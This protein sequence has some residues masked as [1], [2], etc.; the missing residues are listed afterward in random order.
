MAYPRILPATLMA[1][2]ALT[3]LSGCNIARYWWQYYDE[4]VDTTLREPTGYYEHASTIEVQDVLVVPEDLERPLNDTSLAV[5]P[6]PAVTGAMIGSAADIRPPIVPLRLDIGISG[7]YSEN[8]AIIWFDSRGS[9]GIHTEDDALHLMERMLSNIGVEIGH[10]SDESY[11]LTTQVADYDEF[12]NR[13]TGG[14]SGLRYVQI[15]RLRVG[16]SQRGGLGIATALMASKTLLPGQFFAG[17]KTLT[18][19]L[20]DV[21][22]QRFAMGFS[23]QIINE[24]EA[25][26]SAH[27]ALPA[28]VTITLEPDNNG[29]QTFVVNAPYD[30]TVSVLRNMLPKF[31]I[32][33]KEYSI[34]HS[35][36]SIE[37]DDDDPAIFSRA[38][39]DAFGLPER[40]FIVRVGIVG[41]RTSVTFYDSDDKPLPD[42]QVNRLYSGFSQAMARE[43]LLFSEQG[44]KYGGEQA[45]VPAG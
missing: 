10:L 39:V 17:T 5:P 26:T 41:G 23:N 15:Y 43:F 4:S 29:R 44:L 13:Y 8:E 28:E 40:D 35:R 2:L 18:D 25:Q 30:A 16:R 20:S 14:S 38:G 37:V 9:H 6:L 1:T 34:S 45:A 32:I 22:L 42:A 11:E 27:Q 12:G 19:V 31:G 24:L 36:F 21:E 33:I 7:Q 3:C